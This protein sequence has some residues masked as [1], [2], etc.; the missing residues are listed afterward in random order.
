MMDKKNWLKPDNF[1]SYFGR[2]TTDEVWKI[3]PNYVSK[4]PSKPPM[5][6]SYRDEDRT[7]W[8]ENKKKRK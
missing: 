8:L 6:H 4:D 2:N 3:V 1:K 5:L 7:K